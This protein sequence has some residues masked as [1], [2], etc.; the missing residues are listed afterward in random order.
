MTSA[1]FVSAVIRSRRRFTYEEAIERMRMTESAIDGLDDEGFR[2]EARPV[3]RSQAAAPPPTPVAA[4]PRA[5][6]TRVGRS[7]ASKGRTAP[8]SAWMR[9][10]IKPQAIDRPNHGSFSRNSDRA[11]DVRKRSRGQR[12]STRKTIFTKFLN[13]F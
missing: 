6:A 4:P 12:S 1:R 13:Y 2:Y 9:R 5:V 3:S 10:V 11:F 8:E 7:R